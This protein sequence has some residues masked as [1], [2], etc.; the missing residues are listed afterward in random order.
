MK[1]KA[2]KPYKTRWMYEDEEKT[3]IQ[4]LIYW[5]KKIFIWTI[6]DNHRKYKERI[7]R[8]YDYAKFGWINY[9]FD[10]SCAWDLFDFKLRRLHKCLKN[11]HAVQE[12]EDMKALVEFTKIVNRLSNDR[13]ERK[14][15]RR[16]DKKWGKI[17]SR[18]TPNYDSNGKIITYTWHSWRSKCP[19]NAS[20]KLKKKERKETRT[21][22]VNAK[23]DRARDVNR[24]AEILIK[25][26]R[27][28]W[29]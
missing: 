22:W 7:L 9:D 10:M 13:Y 23:K 25:H 29:D 11:G 21:I 24:M 18:T 28:W 15:Y 26:G 19:E 16:H 14:Y 5:F 8:A 4:N 12:P 6:S 27:S 3:F 17:E 1:S 2:L 20:D